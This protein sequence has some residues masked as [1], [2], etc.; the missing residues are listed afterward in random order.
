MKK[1]AQ[2]ISQSDR[3]ERRFQELVEF[4]K[5]HGHCNVPILWPENPKLGRWVDNQR[6][7]YRKRKLSKEREYRLR[8]L[9]FRFGLR[10]AAW[11]EM[12][13][14]LVKFKSEFGHVNVHDPFP[15]NQKLAGWVKTQRA[16]YKQG[17]LSKERIQKLERIGFVWRRHD[18]AWDEMY[19]RLVRFKDAH[20]HCDVPTKW[21]VDRQ[22][23]RWVAIQRTR[24]NI[25]KKK[26][27]R[28]LDEIEFRWKAR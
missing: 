17:K 25:L 10:K 3:W 19:Q 7:F 23:G 26:S 28:R 15:E 12:Y 4:E 5:T 16:R 18:T 14:Q 9:G 22:L 27:V 8:K 20:G 2:R 6:K 11:K 13:G 1:T 21:N 24:K